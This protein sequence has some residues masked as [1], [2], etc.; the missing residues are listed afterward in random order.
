MPKSKEFFSL[1]KEQ[2]KI[3]NP[4]FDELIEKIPDFEIDQEAVSAFEDKFM[5]VSRA[6]SHPEVTQQV[7]A[8]ALK[9]FNRD[10]EKIITTISEIDKS[11]ADKIASLVQGSSPDTYKRMEVLS[12]SLGELFNK[13]K[14]TP[15]DDEELK[16]ELKKKEATIQEALDKL[17]NVQKEYTEREKSLKTDFENKLHDFKL[18]GELE[19]L[20]GTFTL[21]EAYEK[22]RR[23]TNEIILTAI[24]KT[25]NLKLGSK[26]GQTVVQVLDE[27][28]EPRYNGN[29]PV[30]INQLL[31]DRYKPFL[32]QSNADPDQKPKSKT[33]IVNGSQKTPSRGV[34]TTVQ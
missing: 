19:K 34:S 28:G 17:S 9:P 18:D 10:I 7:R 13:V 6:T 24:K 31:E 22:N 4:K 11:T 29:S 33:V 23:E 5:T 1:L 26:D 12:N 14:T 2:G 15:G 30:T 3:S 27:N 16:K 21:A 20:A 25:H 32:K 8:L